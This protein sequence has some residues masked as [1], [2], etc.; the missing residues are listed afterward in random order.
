MLDVVVAV[1]CALGGY[2]VWLAAVTRRLH[3]RNKSAWYLL[4]FIGLP[5]LILTVQKGDLVLPLVQFTTYGSFFD[6]LCSAI[7]AWMIVELG[8][9]RGTVGPNKYGPD[10]S[11]TPETQSV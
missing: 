2:A 9:L 5:T 7:Y 3:D 8:C 10:S 6:L 1:V 4:L 11:S